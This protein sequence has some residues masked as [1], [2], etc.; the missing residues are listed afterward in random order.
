[1]N[2]ATG[3]R[4][5]RDL[6]AGGEE[7]PC[8]K[9]NYSD[10]G[11]RLR[12]RISGAALF[13]L[14]HG[15]RQMT[16]VPYRGGSL[17]IQSVIGGRHQVT[18]ARRPRVLR[19]SAGARLLALAVRHARRFGNWCRVCPG[20]KEAGLPEYNLEFWYGMF[21]PA[22]TPPAI[23]KKD[24]R[25]D[26]HRD[27]TAVGES[28]SGARGHGGFAVLVALSSSM[29]SSPTTRS[30]GSAWQECES[31]TRMNQHAQVRRVLSACRKGDR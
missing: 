30:S 16:H 1:V 27:A 4:S 25:R 8:G 6:I 19:R 11:Q 26:R 28:H 13:G 21:V 9:L 10:L 20:M 7:G 22:G 12:R 18:S 17:A 3:I 31:Q 24:L 2:P 5:G 29:P 23:V 14:A 15:R